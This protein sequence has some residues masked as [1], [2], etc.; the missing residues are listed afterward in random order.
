MPTDTDSMKNKIEGNL[1]KSITTSRATEISSQLGEVALDKI[2]NEG[3]VKDIPI[4][5]SAISFI[6][7]GNDIQAYY[8]TK[9]IIKFL[10]QL[11]EIPVAERTA[12]IEK[13][14]QED[15]VVV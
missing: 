8:F 3:V 15:I 6:R 13:H 10:T 7:V 11:E 12:F 5:G 2:L 1:I 9:K 4:I 14:T